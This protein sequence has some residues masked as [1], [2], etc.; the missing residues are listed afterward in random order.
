MRGMGGAVNA[1]SCRTSV[2]MLK[3]RRSAVMQ[4]VGMLSTRRVSRLRHDRAIRERI[5]R[6]RPEKALGDTPR[7]G[8]MRRA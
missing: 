7:E 8:T 6:Q 1:G 5:P 2:V 4:H 3:R